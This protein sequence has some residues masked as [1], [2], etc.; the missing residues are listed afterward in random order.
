MKESKKKPEITFFAGPNGS[1]KSTITALIK[2]PYKYINADEIK[3]ILDFS[4][5][6]AAQMAEKMREKRLENNEDFCFE[7][8][9]STDRNLKLLQRAKNVGYFI[10]CFY[11]LTAD[12]QVNVERIRGRVAVGGHDVPEE[13]ILSR[14]DKALALFPKVL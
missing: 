12:P 1:G 11:I 4:D 14:Y 6:E 7:T 13:K 8:V 3:S 9:L 2:P 10:R 5:L